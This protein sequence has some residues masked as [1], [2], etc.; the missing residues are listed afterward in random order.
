MHGPKPNIYAWCECMHGPNLRG[1]AYDETLTP[2]SH[3]VP[4]NFAKNVA[5]HSDARGEGGGEGKNSQL[6][7]IHARARGQ[8]IDRLADAPPCPRT[9]TR[10]HA[11][12]L[13]RQGCPARHDACVKH[14]NCI[15]CGYNIMYCLC[16]NIKHQ[17]LIQDHL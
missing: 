9:A 5:Y 1:V 13:G 4:L 17:S 16:Q 10:R 14:D 11:P 12:S 8:A 15:L 6:K 2:S 3:S 7:L